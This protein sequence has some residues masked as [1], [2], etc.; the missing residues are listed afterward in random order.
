MTAAFDELSRKAAA[1][2]LSEAERAELER[3]LREHPGDRAVL[4]WDQAFAAKLAEKVAGMPAMPGW[5]R[6]ERELRAEAPAVEP[7]R[8]KP[9]PTRRPGVLDRLSEWLASWLGFAVNAQAIAA[10]VVVLQAGVI[11][12]LGWQFTHTEEESRM[13]A[14]TQDATPR[15]PLLRVSFRAD[16]PEAGL[17]RALGAIGGEIVGGP[18]QLG[19]YLVRVKEGNLSVAALRL[20]DSG[21]TELVEIIEAGR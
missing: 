12:V 3:H 11:G 5:E 8:A 1:G 7:T 21:A 4:E 20:R 14:G 9:A 2:T 10:A 18:G 6:T 19:I 13:R 16:L 17:R 15:G